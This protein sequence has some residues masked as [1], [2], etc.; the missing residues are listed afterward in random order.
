MTT[1]SKM[2]QGSVFAL[3]VMAPAIGHAEDVNSLRSG[4]KMYPAN[5][6]ALDTGTYGNGPVETTYLRLKTNESVYKNRFWLRKYGTHS[7]GLGAIVKLVHMSSGFCYM[8]TNDTVGG[9]IKLGNCGNANAEWVSDSLGSGKYRLLASTN[10][11]LAIGTDGT[12]DGANLKLETWA[13]TD[14]QKWDFHS[15]RNLNND[16]AS[17]G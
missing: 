7:S 8:R 14:D 3:C 13:G 9:N 15:C 1:I 6:T 5:A 16:A 17:P 10:T 4:C 12:V 2:I 11:N